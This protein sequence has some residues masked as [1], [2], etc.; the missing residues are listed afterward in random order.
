MSTSKKSKLFGLMM[1]ICAGWS[2]HALAEDSLTRTSIAEQLGWV[3]HPGM[4][5][6]GYYLEQP[7]VYPVGVDKEN[8]IE[9]TGN[10][11]FISM[12]QKTSLEGKV[13]ITRYGQQITSNKAFLY[14][15]PTTFK[16][17]S[18]EMIGDVHLREPNTLVVGKQGRYYFDT[19][20]K[21]LLDILYRMQVG[22]KQKAAETDITPEQMQYGHKIKGLTAWGTAEEF[23]QTKPEIYEL[24]KASYTTCPPLT[25]VWQVKASHILLNKETGRGYATHTRIYVK[26]I[27][28]FYAPY[29]NFPIDSRRKS[30]L[31]WPT[32][33]VS[34]KFGPYVLAPFYWNM[35]PNY[36]MTI[37]PGLLSKR[38][39]QLNDKFRYLTESS[40]GFANVSVIPGDMMFSEYQSAV[41]D[42][43]ANADPYVGNTANITT[44]EINRLLGSSTTRRA[45]TWRDE[46]RFSD[47]WSSH[48][49]VNYASDDYYLQDF[50]S[51]LN[52][53]TQNQLLQEGD[54]Y[55]K[56]KHINFTGRMQSYQT[57]HPVSESPVANQYRR[58]PQLIL[59]AD[60]PDQPLGLEYFINNEI[61][62]FEILS[63]PGVDILQPVGN[64]L[65]VQPGIS[66]PV[67]LPYFF[68]NPRA[69]IALTDYN[70]HQTTPSQTPNNIHRAV[71]IFDLASGLSM[72]RDYQLFHFS[73]QQTL[74]PQAYYAYIPY[75]NQSAI[76][77]FDTTVN[78]LTYDQLFNYNRF[79]GI[80]RIGDTNQ[81]SLGITTR[82]LDN[83]TGL[84]KAR[85]GVGDIIY[86]ANRRVT[87]CNDPT[88]C[89][90][91]P[92]NPANH[93]R[94]SP[95]SAVFDYHLNDHWTLGSNAI[96]NPITK[97]LDNGTLTFHFQPESQK[98]INFS[99]S[100]VRNGNYFSGINTNT[101]KNNLKLTDI[102]AAWPIFHEFSAVGRVSEDWSTN[103]FQNL[104]YGVQ[105]DSCCWAIRLVGGRAFTTLINDVP[106]YNNQVYVQIALKGLG[107]IGSDPTAILNNV[108]GYNSQFGQEL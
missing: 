106:Q 96:V 97:Q 94:L 32:A 82:L 24:T 33:G 51:S 107:N 3:T 5:C 65:N 19:K 108:N 27:P 26:G 78:T 20:A 18:A 64:R 41:R 36:D 56:S 81:L 54:L 53:I 47:N 42:N 49:D 21:S 63:N 68:I 79:T 90:D 34:N 105:Y 37:T 70:L 87:T 59:N 38:G 102:S 25:S 35:A 43:P 95:I 28:V 39:I 29:I 14:R 75:R 92:D 45:L 73:F 103:R 22:T 50:G 104:L 85:F 69:Q 31:L 8:F 74:E 48:V 57:M 4:T 15:D 52:E 62:H 10:Q 44:A 11:G 89:T 23:A 72:Y 101:S 9:I 76:P 98:I 17:T 30:G 88:V 13:T 86:F 2:G 60:Y 93:R 55:Y 7:F 6:D 67:Y 12:Q 100:F 80:D 99:Y 58:W 84:E 66:R 77:N 46:S 40:N 16:L 61:T 91:N 71:P 83:E 1:S